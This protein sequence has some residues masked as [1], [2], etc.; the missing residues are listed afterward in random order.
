MAS[1]TTYIVQ[2]FQLSKKGRLERGQAEKAKDEQAALRKAE[3]MMQTKVGV[4]V[5]REE[6][7]AAA[8]MYGTP[9]VVAQFGRIPEGL[10]EALTA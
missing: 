7:D 8:D 6:V 10:V 5:L 4:I 9:I 2:P 3:R 1:E